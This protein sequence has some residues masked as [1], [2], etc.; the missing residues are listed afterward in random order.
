MADMSEHDSGRPPPLLH[1][2]DDTCHKLNIG[3][4]TLYK[5]VG[6]GQLKQVHIGRRTLITAES[7]SA[8]INHL[9][10]GTN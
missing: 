6:D 8:Y 7:I 3:R 10:E 2:V 1:S 5:L 4:T 9:T